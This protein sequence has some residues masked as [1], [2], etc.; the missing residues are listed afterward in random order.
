MLRICYGVRRDRP[1]VRY[2]LRP[3]GDI[4]TAFPP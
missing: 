3:L 2:A 4:L 1:D